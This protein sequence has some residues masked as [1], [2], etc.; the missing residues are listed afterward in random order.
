MNNTYVILDTSALNLEELKELKDKGIDTIVV[1]F[2][3]YSVDEFIQIKEIIEDIKSAIPSNEELSSEKKIF[4]CIYLA[5]TKLLDYDRAA[6]IG[7]AFNDDVKKYE[8]STNLKALLNRCA[9]S[10]GYAEILRNIL[11][12]Y[13]I[14]SIVVE[15]KDN[16]IKEE[17]FT[18]CWNQVK[19][20]GVWYNCDLCLDSM[21]LD[22][23][24]IAPMFLKSDKDL[25]QYDI[26]SVSGNLNKCCESIDDKTQDILIKEAKIALKK[27]LI[28]IR[29]EE[30]NEVIRCLKNNLKIKKR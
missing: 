22:T 24:I 26:E 20:D 13:N 12:E 1:P 25:I 5:L 8:E 7:I 18:N 15:A 6:E 9:L 21:Y 16:H 28:D 11:G 10:K 27:K 19:L 3:E 2:D 23:G 14:K 30:N 17:G 29:N 4:S